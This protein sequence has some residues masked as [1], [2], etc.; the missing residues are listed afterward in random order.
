MTPNEQYQ[1]EVALSNGLQILEAVKFLKDNEHFIAFR[2]IVLDPAVE[3]VRKE[4]ER[5]MKDLKE[6]KD[7]SIMKGILYNQGMQT[8]FRKLGDMDELEK[9]FKVETQNLSNYLK[10]NGRKTEEIRG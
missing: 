1:A 8:A 2:R 6:D 3:L 10:K 7:G 9:K 4:I 5:G